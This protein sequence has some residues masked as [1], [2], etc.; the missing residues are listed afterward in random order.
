MAAV[1]KEEVRRFITECLKAVGAPAQA[2]LDQADLLLQADRTG[3]F[4]H[5]LNRLEFYVNDIISGACE[6][7]NVPVVLKESAATAWV[8]G[9]NALGATVGHFCMSL[10]MKKAKEA[11]V[12]WVTV[13]ASNHFGMAGW[14]AQKAMREGLIGMAFTNSSPLL[15]PTR[16]KKVCRWKNL[17]TGNTGTSVNP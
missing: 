10:A 11:G 1:A 8:D 5:G 4:S 3:H 6:P 9:K 14:W 2:A 12:G 15:A 7:K 13:K 16:S 17:I